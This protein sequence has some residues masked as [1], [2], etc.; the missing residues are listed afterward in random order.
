MNLLDLVS[1]DTTIKKVANTQQGEYAGPCPKCGG[2]DRFRVQPHRSYPRWTCKKCHIEWSSTEA[3]LIFSGRASNWKAAY[4]Y[5]GKP[6]TPQRAKTR[7]ITPNVAKVMDNTKP[8][9]GTEYN[10]AAHAFVASCNNTLAVADKAQTARDY[11]A[12]R[13]I[14]YA[15]YAYCLGYNPAP[16]NA[17][18]GNT[19]VYVP[20]SIIIPHMHNGKLLKVRFRGVDGYGQAAGGANSVFGGGSI[21]PSA[22][23]VM[24]ESEL[25]AVM[26]WEQT[27]RDRNLWGVVPIAIGGNTQGRLLR[28]VAQVRVAGRVLLAFDNDA[29]G[30][31]ATRYWQQ[32]IEHAEVLPMLGNVK[33]VGDMYKAGIDLCK[34]I[35]AANK[36]E[37]VA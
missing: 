8:V 16:Y 27:R 2:N 21:L 5:T 34:W 37:R 17:T 35:A 3:Y 28:W 6:N 14:T 36:R 15:A 30:Q 25:D 11:L 29:A 33:D 31:D 32:Q 26:L 19:S 13:G 18:W 10:A 24:V 4:Q 1:E 12:R 7:Q 23:V 20:R 22:T 9:F